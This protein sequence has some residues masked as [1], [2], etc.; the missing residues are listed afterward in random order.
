MNDDQ[1]EEFSA[2]ESEV[3]RREAERL[4]EAAA[5]NFS[6]ELTKAR[7]NNKMTKNNT[8]KL[9]VR[10]PKCGSD[11]IQVESY[12]AEDGTALEWGGF[13]CIGTIRLTRRERETLLECER[14]VEASISQ[15]V[16]CSRALAGIRSGR[17]YREAYSTFEAYCLE[18]W[19]MSHSACDILESSDI[20]E[21]RP[22][23]TGARKKKV[24]PR[25]ERFLRAVTRMACYSGFSIPL[26]VSQL[27][28][29]KM[30]AYTVA[31]CGR[32]QKRL[33]EVQMAVRKAF[34]RAE[35]Q[36][37]PELVTETSSP[38]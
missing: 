32:L 25:D 19:G 7:R 11:D 26:I 28:S 34:S 8:P 10:C 21:R 31:A 14:E 27:G 33:R 5:R 4:L 37:D 22:P 30:A 18:R 3:C 23:R 15:F 2:A 24:Q 12:L 35:Y 6:E 16:R 1:Q 38:D 9:D 29:D 20:G 13:Y 17:L 36:T